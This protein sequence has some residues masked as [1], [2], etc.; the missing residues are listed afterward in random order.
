MHSPFVDI[1]IPVWNNPFET[2]ACLSAILTHSPQA[3]L[4]VVDNASSRETQVVLEEF[5]EILGEQALF[6]ASERNLG[7]VPAINLGLTR[8]DSAYAVVIRPNTRVLKGWLTGLLNAAETADIG[9]VS[10][11]F[12]GVG[13]APV[14]PVTRDG[15][16]TET[17]TISFNTLLLKRE[18]LLLLGSFDEK[19]DNGACCLQDYIRR[20]WNEGYRTCVTSCAV[21]DCDEEPGFGS[22]KRLQASQA[23]YQERWGIAR[24]YA[25]YFGKDVTVDSLADAV[26]IIVKGA[27][28][29]HRFTLLLHRLQAEA[30]KL[31]GW[32]CLHLGIDI[33]KLSRLMPQRDF[34]RKFAAIRAAV[35]DSIAVQGLADVPFPGSD[36]A[37][38]FS[39]VVTTMENIIFQ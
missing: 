23:R 21:V 11:L 17:F 18:M 39:R 34:R 22:K 19:L 36:A 37:I 33:Q 7:L 15:R 31:M 1:I 30:F 5:S 10:P 32:D 14:F 12:T 38:P 27:R 26:N 6:I 8:S 35:P 13:A 25:I 20:A 3:R 29:G 24:H 28:Q 16:M 2:R 4:I 9:M